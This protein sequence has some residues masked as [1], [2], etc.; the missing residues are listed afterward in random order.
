MVVRH[1]YLFSR[2]CPCFVACLFPVDL[3]FRGFFVD[4]SWSSSAL[5]EVVD[6]NLFRMVPCSAWASMARVHSRSLILFLCA[7]GVA[8]LIPLYSLLCVSH[9][10]Q[11]FHPLKYMEKVLVWQNSRANDTQKRKELSISLKN[12]NYETPARDRK[13]GEGSLLFGDW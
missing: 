4:A 6:H 2:D 12:N 7:T 10:G 8:D 13:I 1:F 5:D 9:S 11:V 3:A